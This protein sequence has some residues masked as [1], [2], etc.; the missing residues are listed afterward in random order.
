MRCPIHI[1]P[2]FVTVMALLFAF[3]ITTECSAQN[4]SSIQSLQQEVSELKN[5]L[6]NLEALVASQQDQIK[7]LKNEKSAPTNTGSS[8]PAVAV[9][10]APVNALREAIV[11]KW[12]KLGAKPESVQFWR[13]GEQ[14]QSV[15]HSMK[16]SHAGGLL[17]LTPTLPAVVRAT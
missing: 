7:Q 2:A 16:V 14:E 6:K 12:V 4:E 5:R 8:F 17:D 13:D 15:W 10:P 1:K 3:G 11:G 9:Q